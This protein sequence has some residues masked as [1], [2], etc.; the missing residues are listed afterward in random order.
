MDV[1]TGTMAAGDPPR[2]TPARP[3]HW[4]PAWVVLAG[5]CA[6]IFH[7]AMASGLDTDVF[8]HLAAGQWMLQHHAVIR[9]DTFSY[10][11]PG[12][13]WLAEEWGFE[14]VLAWSVAHIGA[15]AYWLIAAIPCC[16]SLLASVVRWRRLGA[17][18]LWANALAILATFGMVLGVAARPQGFSYAFVALELLALTAARADAR[19]LLSL[20]VLVWLWANMHGSFLA[21]IGIL[22]V[23]V[24]V[25]LLATRYRSRFDPSPNRGL[26]VSR[27]LDVKQAA[28]TLAA[29]LLATCVN[30]HGPYLLTYALKVSASGKLAQYI[31]EWQSPDFHSLLVMLAVAG[32]VVAVLL[33]LATGRHPLEL[34]DLILVVGFV[35]A[36]LHAVRF[37]PYIGIVSGGLLAPLS[38][39]RRETIRRTILTPML[40]AVLVAVTLAGPHQPAGSPTTKGSGAEPIA[41]AGWLKSK[42]GRVF[43]TYAWNDY[44]I[45]DRIPVFVDGR[46][47]MYFGTPVLDEY[48]AIEQLKSDPDPILARYRVRWVLWP[49]NQPLSV[50]LS[51]DPSWALRRTFNGSMVFESRLV[52]GS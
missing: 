3:F 17:Q 5:C 23:E 50:F 42:T 27:P 40:A 14:V 25:A 24:V 33:I 2:S 11:V 49:T 52:Q 36:A 30:P 18:A 26:Q 41:A 44:L 31:Q 8:W 6:A 10:T 7:V 4:H 19:W 47:D 38:P 28:V 48:I 13:S 29:S 21:G 20:P 22:A 46:T 51:H 12:H 34:F 32:P 43:S 39:L 37:T 45:H 15:V 35:L 1:I 16:L 9:Q